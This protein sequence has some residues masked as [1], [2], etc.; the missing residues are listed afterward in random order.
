M[1]NPES[2]ASFS[3]FL[4]LC[5]LALSLTVLLS[6]NL[7]AIRLQ[8]TNANALLEQQAMQLGQA[9]QLEEKL[10][11]MMSDL[12]VLALTDADAKAIVKKYKITSSV[13]VA[14]PPGADAERPS[15]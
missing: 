6:W 15:R 2:K 12:L 10:K 14:P 5:L 3:A 9:A 13:P 8:W 11:A 4:P 7:Y 1:S